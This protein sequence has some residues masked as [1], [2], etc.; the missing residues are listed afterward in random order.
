M[1]ASDRPPSDRSKFDELRLADGGIAHIGVNVRRASYRGA[2]VTD[3]RDLVAAW[4]QPASP[5]LLVDRLASVAAQA[6]L[7]CLLV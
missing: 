1:T 2:V 7:D 3:Q 6:A 5:V 4:L